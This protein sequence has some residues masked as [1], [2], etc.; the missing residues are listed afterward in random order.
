M[1]MVGFVL[2]IGKVEWGS[3][4]EELLGLGTA[5]AYGQC[6]AAFRKLEAQVMWTKTVSDL[7]LE[8]SRQ[9]NLN[10][11]LNHEAMRSA[12]ASAS[13]SESESES[14]SETSCIEIKSS[15]L[16]Q[17]MYLKVVEGCVLGCG[18]NGVNVL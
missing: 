7:L 5:R 11:N 1:R 2:S 9:L 6:K 18:T 13:A 14:E 16:T 15:G 4:L 10:L 3:R 17:Y 8:V 12:S